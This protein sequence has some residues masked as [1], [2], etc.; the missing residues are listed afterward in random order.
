MSTLLYS[1]GASER[2]SKGVFLSLGGGE[3]GSL[4]FSD[5]ILCASHLLR[6]APTQRSQRLRILCDGSLATLRDVLQAFLAHMFSDCSRLFEAVGLSSWPQSTSSLDRLVDF[7]TRPLAV[8]Q[9]E[10]VTSGQSISDQDMESWLV[11]SPVV[12][13]VLDIAF[14]MS[15]Y[16]TT[17]SSP[18]PPAE[19]ASLVGLP[20]REEGEEGGDLDTQRVLIPLRTLHPNQRSDMT[21]SLL[22]P[23]TL[24]MI[25]S[26]LPTEVRG[27]LYPLFVS[28]HHGQ[29][30]S[31]LCK[32]LVESGPTLLVIRDSGGH[33]FGGFA[34]VPWQFGPQFIGEDMPYIYRPCSSPSLLCVTIYCRSLCVYVHTCFMCPCLAGSSECFLFSLHPT[35]AVYTA[36]GYNTHYMYLQQSA[37]TMPNGLVGTHCT[38]L[39]LAITITITS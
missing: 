20:V 9:A 33:V 17:V 10:G 28:S 6:G 2:V 5:F 21:S 37:Q 30:F 16:H 26:H 35:M 32:S 13:R 12:G 15:L 18:R 36:T 24:L 19:I 3:G 27:Q 22:C 31:T 25:N 34:A 7:L 8:E 11:S 29:S 38:T 39:S 1:S 23:A 14:G 4:A